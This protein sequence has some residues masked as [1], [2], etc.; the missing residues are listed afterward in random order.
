MALEQTAS[1]E[2]FSLENPRANKLEE[3]VSGKMAESNLDEGKPADPDVSSVIT[4]EVLRNRIRVLIEEEKKPKPSKFQSISTNPLTLVVLSFLLTGLLGGLLTYY[5]TAKQQELDFHRNIQQQELV[6]Q[7]SFSDE[8]NKIRI[9]R[10]GEVWEQ[11]DKNEVTLDSLLDKANNESSM[12]KKEL[13]DKIISVV[14]EDIEVVNK[15]RFWLGEPTYNRLKDYLD[16]TGR[17]VSDMLLGYPGI[18]LSE[19]LKKR[20]KAKQDILQI[21]SLFLTGESESSK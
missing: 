18:D 2:Q 5:Y 1:Q 20:E 4:D 15:N 13:F 17:Y 14:E 10:I 8:L 19:T 21:R 7:Q 11:I 3:I 16:I 9:Q 12:N 6:R